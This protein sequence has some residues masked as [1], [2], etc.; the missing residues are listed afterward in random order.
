[1]TAQRIELTSEG[2]SL[3]VDVDDDGRMAVATISGGGA[4]RASH[5][6]RALVLQYSLCFH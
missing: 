3:Q 6:A 4:S 2:L 1:V 5:Y